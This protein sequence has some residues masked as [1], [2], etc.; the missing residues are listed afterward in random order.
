[1]LSINMADFFARRH[2]SKIILLLII[3]VGA[4]LLTGCGDEDLEEETW[5]LAPEKSVFNVM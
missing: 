2:K 3:F 1:M 4:A 5:V